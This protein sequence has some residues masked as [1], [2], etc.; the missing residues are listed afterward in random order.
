M[1]LPK[2]KARAFGRQTTPPPKGQER[3]VR[4]PTCSTHI[5][6]SEIPWPFAPGKRFKAEVFKRNVIYYAYHVV[7]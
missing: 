2:S 4:L 6:A 7:N 5:R 3:L 1:R